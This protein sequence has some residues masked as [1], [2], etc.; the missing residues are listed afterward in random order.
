MCELEKNLHQSTQKELTAEEM[1]YAQDTAR[2]PF[3][4]SQ[5]QDQQ[6]TV[7]RMEQAA[8]QAPVKASKWN[9]E[10]ARKEAQHQLEA[11]RSRESVMKQRIVA[12]AKDRFYHPTQT[13]LDGITN[14]MKIRGKVA[15]KPMNELALSDYARALD[16]GVKAYKAPEDS[17]LFP[18]E[19][20]IPE[21]ISQLMDMEKKLE[22]LSSKSADLSD[23]Q[24]MSDQYKA[25]MGDAM[26]HHPAARFL[27]EI[28]TRD[29]DSLYVMLCSCV[30]LALYDG[31]KDAG[32]GAKT[33]P[34]DMAK[35]SARVA[36]SNLAAGTLYSSKTYRDYRQYQVK[37]DRLK[38]EQE[39]AA[40]K[41][42][43]ERLARE[44]AEAEAKKIADAKAKA[45]ADLKAKE[46]AE[47]QAREIAAANA[48]RFHQE[49]IN[50]LIGGTDQK[51]N[52]WGVSG[53]AQLAEMWL[54]DRLDQLNWK[55]F[56]AEVA[57]MNIRAEEKVRPR[58]LILMELQKDAV[59]SLQLRDELAE[60]IWTAL[61]AHIFDYDLDQEILDNAFQQA[62][63]GMADE[64]R[65]YED[66]RDSLKKM[67][68]ITE[69]PLTFQDKRLDSLLNLDDKEFEEKAAQLSEQASFNVALV[70]DYILQEISALGQEDAFQ[71]LAQQI[72]PLLLFSAPSAVM[73][74]AE[75]RL[76]L[77][78]QY[79]PKLAYRERILTQTLN[80]LNIPLR[81]RD[82]A[83]RRLTSEDATLEQIAVHLR[84]FQQE[85][86][87]KETAYLETLEDKK[88]TVAQW[89]V[90]D[91]WKD[92]NLDLP[93]G[94]FATRLSNLLDKE[95][96]NQQ[97]ALTRQEYDQLNEDDGSAEPTGYEMLIRNQALCKWPMFQDVFEGAE[98]QVY[99]AFEALVE[100]HSFAFPFMSEIGSVRELENLPYKEF[101]TLMHFVRCNLGEVSQAWS[102]FDALKG[103]QIRLALLPEMMLGNVTN[104]NIQSKVQDIQKEL[105]I[106]EQVNQLRFME[107]MEKPVQQREKYQYQYVDTQESSALLSHDSK[108][109]RR[110][111]RLGLAADFWSVAAKIP[112]QQV[113]DSYPYA[114]CLWKC[115]TLEE[116]IRALYESK[117]TDDE[118]LAFVKSQSEQLNKNETGG[119]E[120]RHRTQIQQAEQ[121]TENSTH[122]METLY[123]K[124]KQSA[125][126]EDREALS[127]QAVQIASNALKSAGAIVS[128]AQTA[129]QQAKTIVK[130]GSEEAK[131]AVAAMAAY[132]KEVLESKNQ[133]KRTNGEQMVASAR[134]N[135]LKQALK[136]ETRG[137]RIA[138]D[139]V[140]RARIAVDASSAALAAA[141]AAEENLK[142]LRDAAQKKADRLLAERAPESQR[143]AAF[144]QAAAYQRALEF[145]ATTREEAESVQESA[146]DAFRNAQHVLAS[147]GALSK[148]IQKRVDKVKLNPGKYQ[149]R[150]GK[151]PSATASVAP[152]KVDVTTEE[153]NR[154]TSEKRQ[155]LE[156]LISTKE[157]AVTKILKNI[158]K[159]TDSAK[160]AQLEKELQ[161]ARRVV[162]LAQRDLR[163]EMEKNPAYSL[164]RLVKNHL[165]I[166]KD[167][168]ECCLTELRF[169]GEEAAVL[170]D[171]KLSEA[172]QQAERADYVTAVTEKSDEL[173]VRTNQLY[174]SLR[175]WDMS[176]G[177]YKLWVRRM[178]PMLAAL[179]QTATKTDKRKNE[180]LQNYGAA[181]W[182]DAL[183]QLDTYLSHSGFVHRKNKTYSKKKL[184]SM[185]GEKAL[186]R[187]L[188]RRER[189][190]AKN[191]EQAAILH[192]RKE[193][194][195]N[196]SEGLLQPLMPQLLADSTVWQHL[197]AGS[198]E[199]AAAYLDKVQKAL[200]PALTAL[201]T[202]NGYGAEYISQLLM[203][204]GSAILDE[205]NSPT[206]TT[207]ETWNMR[208]RMYYDQYTDHREGGT[209][210]G[211]RLNELKQQD[212]QTF[213]SLM[214]LLH[215]PNM[216]L[217]ILKDDKSLQLAMVE[218]KVNLVP[219][220]QAYSLF[221]KANHMTSLE[222]AGLKMYVHRSMLKLAPEDFRKQLPDQLRKFR[223]DQKETDSQTAT[224]NRRMNEKWAVM[225][226]IEQRRAR[227]RS[228]SAATA[229]DR[230][231]SQLRKSAR[232]NPS[233]VMQ[234]MGTPAA[235]ITEP[236]MQDARLAVQQQ[237]KDLPRSVRDFMTEILLNGYITHQPGVLAQQV[238]AQLT[239]DLTATQQQAATAIQKKLSKFVTEKQMKGNMQWVMEEYDRIL[240]MADR[241]DFP[242]EVTENKIYELLL[243]RYSSKFKV[244]APGTAQA[245]RKAASG[246]TPQSEEQAL[247]D[248]WSNQE[249]RQKQ[250]NTLRA[251]HTGDPVLEAQKVKALEALR[252][253][254]Y[255]LSN[256][257][258]DDLIQ[259]RL[260]YFQRGAQLSEVIDGEIQEQKCNNVLLD[261]KIAEK[262]EEIQKLY[263]ILHDNINSIN[264]FN[265]RNAES[266]LEQ[267][268]RRKVEISPEN[269]PQ[270][271]SGLREYFQNYLIKPAG[272]STEK[273]PTLA[274]IR[275]Q[276]AEKLQ[277]LSAVTYL[278]DSSDLL[279]SSGNLSL[280][281]QERAFKGETLRTDM[282]RFFTSLPDREET[283][284]YFQLNRQ[285]RQVFALSVLSA[286]RVKADNRLFSGTLLRDKEVES[287][288]HQEHTL[289]LRAF[290]NHQNFDPPIDY[291]EVMECLKQTGKTA[292]GSPGAP[293]LNTA[294]F[295]NAMR[296]TQVAVAQYAKNTKKDFQRLANGAE[297]LNALETMPIAPAA[298][299]NRKYQNIRKIATMEEFIAQ[300]KE[301]TKEDLSTKSPF[302]QRLL[303]QVLQDRTLLDYS[304]AVPAQKAKSG[305]GSG[306]Y[307]I[308]N[309]KGR[310][311]LRNR[312]IEDPM[313][314]EDLALNQATI[315]KAFLTLQSYQVRDDVDL[316]GRKL[317]WTD[318][319]PGALARMS[320]L[321]NTL[322]NRAI[323]FVKEVEQESLRLNAVRQASNLI[324]HKQNPNQAAQAAYKQLN[325][326][327]QDPKTVTRDTVVDFFRKEALKKETI[328]R[329]KTE[330]APLVKVQDQEKATLMAGI[331]ELNPQ[332][333]D[334]FIKALG[335]REILDISKEGIT[336]NRFG[337][338]NRD[339]V[340]AKGR[341]ALLDEYL[342]YANGTESSVPLEETSCYDALVSALS[343]QVSDDL[344]FTQFGAQQ[345][346]T[347][348]LT[349]N[350]NIFKQARS[351]AVDWKLVSRALQFVHRAENERVVFLEDRELYLTMGDVSETGSF[352]FNS[353]Y[354]RKNIHKSGTRLSRYLL[355]RSVIH[356][357][358]L[359][360]ELM[361]ELPEELTPVMDF[362]QTQSTRVLS[363][364]TQNKLKNNRVLKT[365][366]TNPIPPSPEEQMAAD[367]ESTSFL[368]TM[369]N[370]GGESQ[371]TQTAPADAAS[372][373]QTPEEK[374]KTGA[375]ALLPV[376]TQM[377]DA[378]QKKKLSQGEQ[379]DD[380]ARLEKSLE[381]LSPE[382][383]K[384]VQN[385][386]ARNQAFQE[387]A[388]GLAHT[389]K[390]TEV[391]ESVADVAGDVLGTLAG[392][393]LTT[394][395]SAAVSE[396][397]QLV[398]YL[399]S[400]CTEKKATADYFRK[401]GDVDRMKTRLKDMGLDTAGMKDLDIVRGGLGYEKNEE[402][403][404][405]VGLNLTRSLLFCASPY[406]ATSQPH[407]YLLAMA[408]LTLLGQ[409]TA[410]GKQDNATA[411]R[412]YN[413]LMGGKYRD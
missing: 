274:E 296:M 259:E 207:A 324:D 201:S 333:L 240:Q 347:E 282:E 294:L 360:N 167:N 159:E 1:A 179:P 249:A 400:Y 257:E 185:Q 109:Y 40:E 285:Q 57:Q 321:D 187:K 335:H 79:A 74:V 150:V 382:Q 113:S 404:S 235:S 297:S 191:R 12:R 46:E 13:M 188:D 62:M 288:L 264:V 194:V 345:D 112:L 124:L 337:L 393:E 146:I 342:A 395:V 293:V 90:L 289:A 36:A 48:K 352:Q 108:A 406:V 379:G 31:I 176:E 300:V 186:R 111:H 271:K 227:N 32:L 221:C 314:A 166:K 241:L 58:I 229:S 332:Q 413:A 161:S 309:A 401:S 319:P 135:A 295:R 137:S 101:S 356:S 276:I 35:L 143:S 165:D 102:E 218:S 350:S 260:Y 381:G 41:A 328:P 77:L 351:T 405:F 83:C 55:D 340:D 103:E 17:G 238:S 106:Q 158:K 219:N 119:D 254:K 212:V 43:Q 330:D 140:R 298:V 302:Q 266:E 149:N 94:E 153:A 344:D 290:T 37:A 303:I 307:T 316:T 175:K 217:E 242:G 213:S 292:D 53:N 223:R 173:A 325:E 367:Q 301:L 147:A 86:A 11:E 380:Q 45:E 116:G 129:S 5:Y 97:G 320:V 348:A 156:T 23:L 255:T 34:E 245:Q 403:G 121:D 396:A 181:S 306:L 174:A 125:D 343:T 110:A 386:A 211:D 374:I 71:M 253:G 216:G 399:V 89:E 2:H 336:A 214:T 244:L 370:L 47:A 250:I 402:L 152:L 366:R 199:D 10:T 133:S 291:S 145:V 215:D 232:T 281:A 334:L 80:E 72:A 50:Y 390:C 117:A 261:A 171:E 82:Q 371:E 234:V 310:E 155:E 104:E 87:Q 183:S 265:V 248:A 65:R 8:I 208:F 383:A 318:F 338:G 131:N 205:I 54:G 389:R 25:L 68:G 270:L 96:W 151:A 308:V 29:G 134:E 197:M 69:L 353:G 268:Q 33:I 315:S 168:L 92:E 38:K 305:K 231:V 132:Q 317:R 357:Q 385:A 409:Q 246:E 372:I 141:A 6:N 210:I 164:H 144:S 73:A 178:Q 322:L 126:G 349:S 376:F 14:E 384:R 128:D 346:L 56:T 85:L 21:N 358:S 81:W 364:E 323:E 120:I 408:S 7:R 287:G 75:N 88:L 378:H 182:E 170:Q 286:S 196:Q 193:M 331:L 3:M 51:A 61:G 154:K 239:A 107:L 118:V 398:N 283:A 375:Q 91:H 24:A 365:W 148:S 59:S 363:P 392:P 163:Q 204:H 329:E 233:L 98:Q 394:M 15:G 243:A 177:D 263:D 247:K 377:Y 169:L 99:E 67:A 115:T 354:M 369:K 269:L 230:K 42:H 220:Q 275:A 277:D 9:Q 20:K 273:L 203:R 142:T 311:R 84:S 198:T 19:V 362:L 237:Y 195:L 359:V 256:Q 388:S 184:K 100:S 22:A 312:W 160:L 299:K 272:D 209:S 226:E 157:Q 130:S 122:A 39:A 105:G 44:I 258:F 412:V 391:L 136:A 60:A 139:S 410:A 66:H 278:L 397:G 341:N 304:T 236:L 52:Q 114:E 49:R 64:I 189:K 411:N 76:S 326:T 95:E 172:F 373:E 267:L 138:E 18:Q 355:R 63:E 162:E 252:Y 28:G 368:E 192:T 280:S 387:K 206:D 327:Y 127:R 78:N 123:E 30:S 190:Q 4:V 70:K 224:A 262:Q 228:E 93:A 339:Y 313:A 16:E 180:Y 225:R 279:T 284:A 26:S 361:D 222:V 27:D 202:W 407:L 251:V 200:T